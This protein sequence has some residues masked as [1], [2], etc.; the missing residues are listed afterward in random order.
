MTN[1][2]K[3]FMDLMNRVFQPYLDQFIIVFI[4]NI[5]IYSKSREEHS[6]HL[7]TALQILKDRQLY[8]KFSKCE[9]WLDRVVF[10]GHIISRD[11]VEVDPSKVEAVIDWPVP[12]SVTEIRSFLGLAGYYK[13]FIQGFSSITVPLTA[14]AK[15]NVK[16]VCYHP[17]KANVVANALN[18]KNAVIAQLSVQRPLRAENHRYE[19]AVFGGYSRVIETYRKAKTALH[20]PVEMGEHHHEFFYRATDD[21]WKCPSCQTG[22]RDLHLHSGRVCIKYWVPSCYSVQPSTQTASQSNRMIQILVDLLRACVIDFHGSWELKLPLVEFTYNNSYQASIVGDHVFVKVA[23]MKGV[24][25]FGKKGKL[26][27]RFIEPFKIPERVVTLA[28]RVVLQP[29]LAGVHNVFNVS[30][31]WKY[32]SNLS[33]VLNYEPLHLTSNLSFEERPTYILDKH[34]RRLRNK[35]ILMV[36]VK[37]MIHSEEEATWETKTEMKSRYPELFGKF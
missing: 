31:L 25:R 18:V 4:D 29:N 22:T 21:K 12:K 10:L 37:W 33:H 11:G 28:Y 19:L 35:V 27:S 14:L 36:K 34:E 1:A 3:I 16:F 6:R 5:L 32:M 2:P 13:K 7:R 8:A 9:F 20:S 15:K 30:I 26:G 24:M 23:S 17:R